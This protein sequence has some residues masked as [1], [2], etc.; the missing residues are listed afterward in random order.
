M[1]RRFVGTGVNL[2]K[3][4]SMPTRLVVFVACICALLLPSS[5]A[6]ADNP[7]LVASVG[8]NDAFTISLRGAD[9][10]PVTHLDPGTYTIVVHDL[11]SLH[12][13]HLSG[14]G[15]NQKTD[16]EGTGDVTWTVTL[17]DG[18]YRFV[19]DA[20]A[21]VMK[22]SFTVGKVTTPTRL[23]GSV[24][25][26]RR[27]SLRK[28][29]GSKPIGLAAEI[30]VVITVNDRSR[31]DNFHLIGTGVNRATG[32]RFRGKSTWRLTLAPGKYVFRSDRHRSLRGSFT[33]SSS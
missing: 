33:V 8:T 22:G 18:T 2:G 11:S 28:A 31:T 14:P 12:N 20:H 4:V 1:L 5:A 30:Q 26:G 27:I 10:N 32:I 9:N 17:T 25:P 16:I 3:G 13:F 23:S 29:D 6:R 19:C 15:V 7:Q 21:G 24:G